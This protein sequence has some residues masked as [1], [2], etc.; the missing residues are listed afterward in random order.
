MRFI[1]SHHI[2]KSYDEERK[3]YLQFGPEF[4]REKVLRFSLL[5]YGRVIFYGKGKVKV[6]KYTWIDLEWC[7]LWLRYLSTL[8]MQPQ[9]I[10][11][12]R[13]G[14]LHKPPHAS[15]LSQG[16]NRTVS[17]APGEYKI[18]W[19]FLRQLT[20]TNKQKHCSYISKYIPQLIFQDAPEK[21]KPF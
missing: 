13:M 8:L 21:S 18:Y 9:P 3:I 1:T 2:F 6:R 14:S 10:P 15:C 11:S 12:L 20:Q 19:D 17:G 4:V 7:E 16:L 5:F